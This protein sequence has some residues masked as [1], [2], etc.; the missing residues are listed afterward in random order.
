M[1][2]ECGQ[3]AG[4]QPPRRRVGREMVAIS[5]HV[6]IALIC[7]RRRAG[8]VLRAIVMLPIA[9]ADRSSTAAAAAVIAAAVRLAVS[10]QIMLLVH[11]ARGRT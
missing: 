4:A 10:P 2:S 3:N 6:V 11:N 1:R 5:G 7:A 9:S 8:S